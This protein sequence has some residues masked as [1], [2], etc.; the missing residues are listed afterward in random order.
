[1]PD[2]EGKNK[3]WIQNKQRQEQGQGQILRFWLRQNDDLQGLRQNDDLQRLRQNDDVVENGY[4]RLII[5][6]PSGEAR[7]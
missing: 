6:W 3:R 4:A 2:K 1:M 7:G 5:P